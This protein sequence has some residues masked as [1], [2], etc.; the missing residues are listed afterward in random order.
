MSTNYYLKRKVSQERKDEV[1]SLIN[2]DDIE[3]AAMLINE[4]MSEAKIH[5]GK[6]SGGWQ[7]LWA[8][9]DERYYE[10]SQESIVKFIADEVNNNGSTIIDEYN[11][12]IPLDRFWNEEIGE[13]LRCG[14]VTDEDWMLANSIDPKKDWFSK[15]KKW[16]G[17]YDV[18]ICGN[19][20]SEDGLKF[21]I[22]EFC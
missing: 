13:S 20:I 16:A 6:R 2:G 11:E 21:S 18:N 8:L 22:E 14:N 15:H 3:S 9:N 5:L 12:V 1:I 17:K 4:M 7:F 10:P 19:F